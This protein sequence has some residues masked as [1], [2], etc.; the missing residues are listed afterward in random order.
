[1]FK[2]DSRDENLYLKQKTYLE[3][4]RTRVID[5]WKGE[6]VEIPNFDINPE[7]VDDIKN[8]NL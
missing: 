6:Q 3:D 4:L 1:M 2:I 5:I 8:Y 7:F